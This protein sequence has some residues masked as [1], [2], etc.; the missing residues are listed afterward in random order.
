MKLS[1]PLLKVFAVLLA[2][3]LTFQVANTSCTEERRPLVAETSGAEQDSSGAA[4]GQ[5]SS[6]ASSGSEAASDSSSAEDETE[7][8]GSQSGSPSQTDEEEKGRNISA[9]S[10]PSR[11][12]AE[13]QAKRSP[14]EQSASGRSQ[15]DDNSSDGASVQSVSQE[16]V[17]DFERRE[18]RVERNLRLLGNLLENQ[19]K[20]AD[21]LLN[22]ARDEVSKIGTPVSSS[23]LS[24]LKVGISRLDRWDELVRRV[25]R[26]QEFEHPL[27]VKAIIRVESNGRPDARNDRSTATGLMQTVVPTAK[28][29]N[30]ALEGQSTRQT[31]RLLENPETS[32]RTGVRYLSKFVVPS[33]SAGNSTVTTDF[34]PRVARMYYLGHHLRLPLDD[35][36]I[37]PRL[38]QKSDSYVEKVMRYYRRWK[39][40]M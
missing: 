29:V 1:N 13:G 38:L 19:G 26:N 34:L 7:N 3:V 14:E 24:S 37:P 8:D 23:G 39:D 30:P 16:Q 22:S 4:A 25:C 32:V 6:E 27:F 17:G 35:Q 11:T 20:K 33:A 21:S 5:D 2:A 9:S 15:P 31:R 10:G 36:N 18:A 12:E 40:D 28:R